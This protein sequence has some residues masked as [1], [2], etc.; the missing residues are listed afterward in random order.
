MLDEET[1]LTKNIPSVIYNLVCMPTRD[2]RIYYVAASCLMITFLL[3]NLPWTWIHPAETL[4]NLP[5]LMNGMSCD[6]MT[7]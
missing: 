1:N 5:S 6:K 3:L 2:S 7:A 4:T